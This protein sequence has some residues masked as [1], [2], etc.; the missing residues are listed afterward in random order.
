MLPLIRKDLSF[1]GNEAAISF[2]NMFSAER[3]GNEIAESFSNMLILT[4]KDT[5]NVPAGEYL[6]ILVDISNPGV[7]VAHCHIL[8][9]IEA[10]MVFPFT[11]EE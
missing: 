4:W 11:V 10:G 2:R 1:F 7:W 9:H 8:E 3:K 5:V 6:D